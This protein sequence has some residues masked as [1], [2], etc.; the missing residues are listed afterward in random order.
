M[1][2]KTI[3]LAAFALLAFVAL[4][5]ACG[6]DDSTKTTPAA[7]GATSGAGS[8]SSPGA[9]GTKQSGAQ[10]PTAAAANSGKLSDLLKDSSKLTFY[11]VYSFESAGTNAIKGTYTLAQKPPKSLS[12]FDMAGQG[13]FATINDG[14]QTYSCTKLG[15]QPTGVCQ[16]SAAS[17]AG[18][19]LGF[20]NLAAMAQTASS[21]PDSKEI[22]GR[23]VAGRD[24]RCFQYS[25]PGG[26]ASIACIDKDSGL[27]VYI[28]TNDSSGKMTITATDIK[29]SVDDKVFELPYKV[30]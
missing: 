19:G 17:G 16:K 1:R 13:T 26:S 15:A 20:F 4:A 7:G 2:M 6:D 27:M 14:Q 22:A 9:E 30:Q 28:E 21:V 29:G 11:V 3:F 23:K 10:S 12:S 24:A 25:P 5:A 18:A 8:A